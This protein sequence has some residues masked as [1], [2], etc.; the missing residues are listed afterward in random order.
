[1]N[2]NFPAETSVD[3]D[4][5]GREIICT[6][7]GP[8]IAW[9]LEAADPRDYVYAPEGFDHNDHVYVCAEC[10]PNHGLTE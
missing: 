2:R 1:M 8:D 3:C 7:N 10:R 9:G 4:H 5:C 6:M